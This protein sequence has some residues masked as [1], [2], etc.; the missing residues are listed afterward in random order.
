MMVLIVLVDT[1]KI[2]WLKHLS[3]KSYNRSY[4]VDY[5]SSNIESLIL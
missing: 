4:E 1:F 2:N 5:H 3:K